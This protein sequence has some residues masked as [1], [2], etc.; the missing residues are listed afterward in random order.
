MPSYHRLIEAAFG[1]KLLN[2]RHLR[3]LHF[4]G[5]A[6]GLVAGLA[7]LIASGQGASSSTE[8]TVVITP[9]NP[10]SSPK[11]LSAEDLTKPGPPPQIAIPILPSSS[12]LTN[13]IVSPSM[14]G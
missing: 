5:L 2:M 11:A 7:P 4:F 6:C 1:L 14:D 10:S 3:D 9:A 8:G 13:K 12:N